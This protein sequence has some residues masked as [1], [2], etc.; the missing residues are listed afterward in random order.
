MIDPLTFATA[1]MA[2]PRSGILPL[3]GWRVSGDM[4]PYTFY[5]SRRGNVV[6]FPKAPPLNPPSQ[7]QLE[8]RAKF[9]A[10][11]SAWKE[12]NQYQQGQW[13]L[14]ATKA[15][16]ICTG[17]NLFVHYIATPTTAYIDT[18]S[19]QSGITLPPQQTP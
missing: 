3:I 17:Y 13:Q 7:Q 16:C 14:A 1:N 9:I 6:Y 12:L 5:T 18:V 15:G 4:G 10:A 11:A 8:Q 2:K 19:R